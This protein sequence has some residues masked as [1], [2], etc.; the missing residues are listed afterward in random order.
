MTERLQTY[1]AKRPNGRWR[2]VYDD[3]ET[4]KEV[5]RTFRRKVDAEAWLDT[6]R[7]EVALGT[8]INPQ[9]AK[10]PFQAYAD[11][12]AKAQIHRAGTADDVARG[13]RLHTYPTFGHR[14][15]GSIKP[16]EVQAWV[17][18]LALSP[19]KVHVVYRWFA[20]I[21]LS[22]V[23]DELIRQTPCR[24]ITLPKIEG[25]DMIVPLETTQVWAIHDAVP[26]AVKPLVV[27]GAGTGLRQGELFGVTWDRIDWLRRTLRVD[28]QL[29]NGAFGPCKTPSSVRNV[30]LPE[31]VIQTLSAMEHRHDELVFVTDR[32][33]PWGRPAFSR[34]WRPAVHGLG[35]DATCHDLRHYYASLLIHQ[36]A[37]VKTVQRCLG[38]SSA[39]ITLDTY[40]HL[41]P[42]S[43][44]EVRRAIDAVL[45]P[46]TSQEQAL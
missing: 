7:G 26:E 3:P 25:Q 8:Y 28:R 21:M 31:V 42:D 37:S 40:G 24:R 15:L 11:G 30:P 45:A 17:K 10:T 27:V 36:G 33:Q 9:H 20:S 22:A 4:A 1:V 43:E 32:G 6:V 16:S 2:A 18:G 19:A 35:I 41:W 46:Q 39:T 12:W 14:A 34:A 23:H 44:D 29:V 5:S 13:L 38:H